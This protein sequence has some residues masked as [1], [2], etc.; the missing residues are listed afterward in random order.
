M[1][2]AA[3]YAAFDPG[4]DALIVLRAEDVRIVIAPF[5]A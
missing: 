3:I 4:E 1:I 2:S 5:S